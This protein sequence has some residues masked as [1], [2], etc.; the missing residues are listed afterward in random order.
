MEER[1]ELSE[2]SPG[3]SR[4]TRRRQREPAKENRGSDLEMS[5]ACCP[6]RECL[7]PEPTGK[8]LGACV[9]QGRWEG[10]LDL[11]GQDC[12]AQRARCQKGMF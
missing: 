1:R 5:R 2:K 12:K 11:G 4:W 6:L 3:A 9:L 7:V 8:L 10:E